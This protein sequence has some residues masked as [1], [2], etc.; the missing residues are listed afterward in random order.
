[1]IK[2]AS[3][4]AASAAVAATGLAALSAPGATAAP[5][6]PTVKFSV[7][8]HMLV[9]TASLLPAGSKTCSF[10]RG[11]GGPE[12]GSLG[13]LI[14]VG[15]KTSS[16]SEITIRSKPVHAGN[17]FVRM[18]CLGPSNGGMRNVLVSKEGNVRVS[19][20]PQQ[21]QSPKPQ[22]QNTALRGEH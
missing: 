5:P 13:G 2:A 11:S 21:N 9:A 20:G 22:P 8:D 14:T 1:M 12:S 7:T 4:F 3:V 6:K 17:Y 16:A 18:Q 19:V 15:E 10:Y